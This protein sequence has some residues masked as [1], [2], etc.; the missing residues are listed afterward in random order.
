MS[1]GCVADRYVRFAAARSAVRPGAT[2]RLG[3]DAN[4][5]PDRRGSDPRRRLG[6]IARRRLCGGHRDRQDPHAGRARLVDSIRGEHG[7]NTGF[8]RFVSTQI[9]EE[10]GELQLRLL[11]SH[12]C[13]VGEPY[14]DEVVR[15]AMLLRANT[16]AKGFSGRGSAPSNCSS[17]ASIA[18]SSRSC[19]RA[20]RLVRAVI[21]RRSRTSPSLSS[22]RARQWSRPT[23]GRRRGAPDRRA[24]PLRP[25]RRG[26]R[27]STGRSS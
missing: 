6:R 15:G 14:P 10:S 27:S 4:D 18:A 1:E 5:P 22:G 19:R 8:G 13:G 26:S 16:L 21:S 2:T 9:P 24:R 20:A 11:R 25:A 17:S 23:P 3:R 12:A 7:V